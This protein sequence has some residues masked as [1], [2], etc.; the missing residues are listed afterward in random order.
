MNLIPGPARIACG[1]ALALI[2]SAYAGAASPQTN[3]GAARV[4]PGYSTS[5]H[6]DRHD[7]DFLLGA[8]TLRQ[9]RLKATGVGSSEWEDVSPNRHCAT[10]LLDGVPIIDQSHSPAGAPVG[11]F[12]FGYDGAKR[13]WS[14]F[15][16]DAKTGRP[17]AG[18][19]GGFS[20]RRG[21]FYGPDTDGKGRPIKV[22]V[23]WTVSG[24]DHSR[25]EQAFSYDDRTWEI[26]WVAD[27]S[28]ADP[29]S[30]CGN[31][32]LLNPPPPVAGT[33]A[34]APVAAAEAP[35]RSG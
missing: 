22:R 7:F 27:F 5:V 17:D 16:I 15:W 26:N 34:P 23:I 4:P 25:W 21:E 11:L 19:V 14:M 1:F 20:G 6:G 35:G 9:R 8:W 31:P 10:A 12:L 29:K 33:P 24:P 32:T 3:A 18:T 13:Q 2:S 30:I 28:R